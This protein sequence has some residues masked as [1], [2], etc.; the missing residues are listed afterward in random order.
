M[1]ISSL[2]SSYGIGTMGKTAYEFVDFLFMSG[3]RFWQILPLCPTGYGDSPYQSF[4]SF[5]GNPYLIDLEILTNEGYLT[6]GDYNHLFWGEDNARVNYGALYTERYKVLR[7]AADRFK[8]ATPEDFEKFIDENS[9]WLED[10]AVFMALKSIN[11]DSSWLYWEDKYRLR[12]SKTMDSVREEYS[13]EIFFWEAVQYLFYKQWKELKE[14]ANSK[15]IEIIGDLPI[16]TAMDSADVWA[17][18]G[19][20]NLDEN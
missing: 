18:P 8:S 10:Y 4:S 20:F 3:Q 1:H 15:G 16:Y 17:N 12:D 6:E 14:Y 19:L 9:S 13:E 11:N 2:P 7:I 5:A